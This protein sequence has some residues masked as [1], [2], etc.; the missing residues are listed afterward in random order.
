MLF[1]YGILI[2]RCLV[3]PEFRQQVR[4]L[5]RHYS[6]AKM[7]F[8]VLRT[9]SWG[10]EHSIQISAPFQVEFHRLGISGPHP[11]IEAV[12]KG[13]IHLEEFKSRMSGRWTEDYLSDRLRKTALL[14]RT[15]ATELFSEALIN[16]DGSLFIHDGY[17]RAGVAFHRKLA[18]AQIVVSAPIDLR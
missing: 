9:R 12:A 6:E 16:N 2:P 8:T 1:L 11:E 15:D 7:K 13:G 17:H 18:G 10:R 5:R 4:L 14:L 3:S